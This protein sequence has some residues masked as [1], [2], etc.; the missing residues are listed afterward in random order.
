[1]AKHTLN[2]IGKKLDSVAGD[3]DKASH[4]D[5]SGNVEVLQTKNRATVHVPVPESKISSTLLIELHNASEDATLSIYKPA[6]LEGSSYESANDMRTRSQFSGR[7][8][9]PDDNDAM[10]IALPVGDIPPGTLGKAVIVG[11]CLV[12]IVGGEDVSST[13]GIDTSVS[14]EYLVGS[15]S[16]PYPVL[17]EEEVEDYSIEHFAMV[18]IGISK[19]SDAVERVK[20]LPP[21]PSTGVKRVHWMSPTEATGA[22]GDGQLWVSSA[23]QTKYTPE[24]W[25]TNKSGVPVP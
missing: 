2:S 17:W 8:L 24:Q 5:M 20:K 23:G 22:T 10:Y 19:N 21:L 12:K 9:D 6:V 15:E 25:S 11:V 7:I 18:M 13:C 14:E 3:V 16:G 4:P 1:M